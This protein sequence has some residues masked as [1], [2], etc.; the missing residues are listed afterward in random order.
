MTQL[1]YA[2]VE[3]IQKS[4]NGLGVAA[5]VIGILSLLGSWVPFCGLMVI[6]LAIIGVVLGVVGMFVAASGKRSG[7]GFPVVGTSVSGGAI[8]LA[9]VSTGA[10]I[11]G[12]NS[13]PGAVQAAAQQQLAAAAAAAAASNAT[14][15]PAGALTLAKYE[16]ITNGMTYARVVEIVGAEGTELADST[17]GG[18]RTTKFYAWNGDGGFATMTATFSDGKLVSKAQLGLN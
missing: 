11:F 15:Q 14:T 12:L 17:T 8:V 7:L 1:Q 10:G 16:Q 5:L 6:P 3:P 13:M 2:P 18:G 4:V 9:L